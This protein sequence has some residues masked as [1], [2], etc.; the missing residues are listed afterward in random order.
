[1]GVEMRIVQIVCSL[2]Y[3]DGVSKCLL[4]MKQV[5][6]KYNYEN[7]IM[8]QLVDQQVK[9]E[10]IL[11]D[12]LKDIELAEEDIIIYHF[13]YGQALNYDIE[14]LPNRKIIV[15]Q[16]VTPACFF[17][18]LDD[19]AFELSLIGEY[20]AKQT[21]KHYL[22]CITMSAFSKTDLINMGWDKQDVS[23]IPLI[24]LPKQIECKPKEVNTEDEVCILF[25][26][27]IAPNKKHEDIISAFDYYRK[28]VN[29]NSRLTLVGKAEYT[30]YEEMLHRILQ[31]N[32][33]E[34]VEFTGHISNEELEELYAKAD[35][36][37]CMSEHEGLCIP[38]LEAMER[39]VPVIAY[40]AAAIPDTMGDA[41]ILVDNK[42]LEEISKYI[43]R[44]TTDNEYRQEIIAKQNARLQYFRDYNIEEKLQ[45]VLQEVCGIAEWQYAE[46]SYAEKYLRSTKI[47]IKSE[48]MQSAK[49]IVVYGNG[50]RGKRFLELLTDEDAEKVV[51][52]C[53]N[54]TNMTDYQGIP[55]LK[56]DVCTEQYPEALYVIT[57]KNGSVEIACE[58]RLSGVDAKNIKIYY[59]DKE[60]V[61]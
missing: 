53:D 46:E 29:H 1:M 52:I 41:G 12:N 18:K 21:V 31:E 24:Q 54:G 38:L 22:K 10:V 40:N 15:Y 26:G 55:I 14:G 58:L 44:L 11:F 50:V 37:L 2:A 56:H 13:C 4:M 20:D 19:K 42:N 59:A 9:E 3:G 61:G 8:S 17:R 48:V 6:D 47:C 45:E 36:F 30:E 32:Q 35:V 34:G 5:L 33:V 25:I 39:Q 57:P 43:E 27:R 28:N 7:L 60:L 16:N 23:V 51:A 49:Q